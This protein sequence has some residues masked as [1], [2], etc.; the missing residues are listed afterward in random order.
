LFRPAMA[1]AEK[2]RGPDAPEFNHVGNIKV[3]RAIIGCDI[4][5]VVSVGEIVRTRIETFAVT[6]LGIDLERTAKAVV[7]FG[8]QGVEISRTVV[9]VP[10]Q[11]GDD[12]VGQ[13]ALSRGNV[14]KVVL[15]SQMAGGA[16]LVTERRNPLVA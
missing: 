13:N 3:R 8:E 9:R 2:R 4:V 5:L 11:S 14:V 7:Q 6:I 12:R 10:V 16:A 1:A 15:L